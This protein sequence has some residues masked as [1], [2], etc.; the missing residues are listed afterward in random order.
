MIPHC[1]VFIKVYQN[2]LVS[3]TLK[4]NITHVKA[5]SPSVIYLGLSIKYHMKAHTSKIPIQ[6]IF[7]FLVAMVNG[8]S[9]TKSQSPM[10]FCTH[11][12]IIK[13]KGTMDFIFLNFILKLE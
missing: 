3:E 11:N 10:L 4:P 13:D 2:I 12:L 9:K 7:S 6:C 8:K 1:L 5:F